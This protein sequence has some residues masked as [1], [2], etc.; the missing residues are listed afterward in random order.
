MKKTTLI[1]VLVAGLLLTGTLAFSWPGG[2][3]M[4]GGQG[5]PC[6]PQRMTAEQGQQRQQIQL[7]RMAVILD[8]TEEQRQQWQSLRDQHRGQQDTL[9]TDMRTRRAQL[10]ELLRADD[11]D[12]ERIRAAIQEQAELK[13]RMIVEG[14]RHRQQVAA[15]LTPQQQEK[16]E[17]LGNLRGERTF[18]KRGSCIGADSIPA[19]RGGR[20]GGRASGV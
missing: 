18:G 1:S 9:W 8:L 20:R 10:R 13:T 6:A 11:A 15:L 5:G 17:Q 7:E 19:E 12:E 14:N 16:M 3:G 2:P 4:R